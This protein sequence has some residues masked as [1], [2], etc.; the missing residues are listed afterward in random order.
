MLSRH[1][2]AHNLNVPEMRLLYTLR[3]ADP[4][5][6]VRGGGG[7]GRPDCRKTS[8]TTLFLIFN[9]QQILQFYRGGGGPVFFRG[10]P[11]FSRGVQM[12]ISIKTHIT[13]DFPEG[14]GPPVPPLDP[15]MF[16]Q[17]MPLEVSTSIPESLS[18][19]LDVHKSIQS[20]RHCNSR[21]VKVSRVPV[22]AT[23]GQEKYPEFQS[24]P[25]EFSM[26]IKRPCHCQ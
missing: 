10:G 18:L 4:G 22:I 24:L 23:R 5:I 26:S 1:F 14:S 19:P 3:C 16:E 9:P 7:G 6:F 13:C 17:S 8:A 21:L 2:R 11:T 25:Q 12:L 15:Y 20:P